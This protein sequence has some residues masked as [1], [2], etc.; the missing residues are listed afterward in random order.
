MS[1]SMEE[2]RKKIAARLKTE[3]RAQTSQRALTEELQRRGVET[4][5][6]NVSQWLKGRHEPSIVAF[7]EI[8]DILQV[9]A[10]AIMGLWEGPPE[11]GEVVKVPLIAD[12]Q[13]VAELD[14][15]GDAVVSWVTLDAEIFRAVGVGRSWPG[16][17]V[18][19]F[20]TG[21]DCEAMGWSE[22]SG[23]IL[24]RDAAVVADGAVYLVYDAVSE[25]WV[26]RRVWVEGAALICQGT[27][28]GARPFTLRPGADTP[29]K[30]TAARVVW[31]GQ[32]V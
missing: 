16:R 4:T 18:L 27:E 29:A 19:T 12:A 26:V 23:L 32:P 28:C 21:L 10:D 8:C 3:V 30:L 1:D 25:R 14:L 20:T 17:F 31:V 22:H 9:S 24:D 5:E 15:D 7:R 13:E 6:G 11:A 2:R